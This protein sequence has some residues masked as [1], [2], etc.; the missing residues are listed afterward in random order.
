MST[1]SRY[2]Y[3]KYRRL[4]IFTFFF[5]DCSLFGL[6]LE[7]SNWVN[8]MCIVSCLFFHQEV[9]LK[10]LFALET[11]QSFFS[12]SSSFLTRSKLAFRFA[13]RDE[14]SL[15]FSR[16]CRQQMLLWDC[17]LSFHCAGASGLFAES[18]SLG[19]GTWWRLMWNRE[20]VPSSMLLSAGGI[21]SDCCWGLQCVRCP[22]AQAILI[23][24][25]LC[26]KFSYLSTFICLLQLAPKTCLSSWT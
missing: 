13:V 26:V 25:R 4:G 6:F 20:L 11:W 8:Q 9:K 21:F 19:V 2:Y 18:F 22:P 24:H 10:Y 5:L 15:F 17:L 1:V 12:L 3:W 14:G 16:L 7:I 23:I